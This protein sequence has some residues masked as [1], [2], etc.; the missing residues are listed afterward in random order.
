[1]FHFDYL[2]HAIL[3]LMPPGCQPCRYFASSA[4]APDFRR[5]RCRA[6]SPG[7]AFEF[8]Y[9]RVCLA[10]FR[11]DID[12]R[13]DISLFASRVFLRFSASSSH[14]FTIF[15]FFLRYQ[16]ILLHY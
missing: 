12:K 14:I 7:C 3:R 2:R 10:G 9:F 13:I 16:L 11:D 6:I 5:H 1:M 8:H 4:E 15:F